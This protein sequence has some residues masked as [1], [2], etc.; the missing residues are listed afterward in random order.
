MASETGPDMNLAAG[1]GY[2]LD[3]SHVASCRLNLQ[4]YLWK[5]AIGYHVHPSVP[6]SSAT[7]VA[8]VAA[9]TGMW[10][11]D[12]AQSY[13]NIQFDGFDNNTAQAPDPSNIPKNCTMKHWNFFED[14]PQEMEGRY[15]FVHI[16]L[17]V[18]AIEEDKLP[19]IIQKLQKMLKPNGYLQW[20]ELDLVHMRVKKIS[21]DIPSPALDQLVTLS[22]AG[23]RYDWTFKIKEVMEKEG[24]KDVSLEL[25]GDPPELVRPMNELHLMSMEEIAVGFLKRGQLE[26]GNRI[27]GLIKE[28]YVE[29]TKG[30]TLYFPR[31]VCVGHI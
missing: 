20:D 13:P 18:L 19:S 17:L 22:K 31:I 30:A 12:L 24:F 11:I 14:L 3:R 15:D 4:H 27:Y 8:D 21:P 9:G 5:T 10:L 29:A 6:I 28:A 23:G 26:M 16:R 7:A 2:M 25:V 1:Q